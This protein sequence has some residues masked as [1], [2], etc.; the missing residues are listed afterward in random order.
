MALSRPPPQSMQVGLTCPRRGS[1][2]AL[3][4]ETAPSLLGARASKLAVVPQMPEARTS[5]EGR[6]RWRKG[7]GGEEAG[8]EEARTWGGSGHGGTRGGEGGGKWEAVRR[9]T[10]GERWSCGLI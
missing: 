2:P 8:G 10:G 4:L 5:G 1:R 3:L 7:V 9:G 6:V